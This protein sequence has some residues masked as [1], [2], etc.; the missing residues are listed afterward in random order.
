METG[1]YIQE[2]NQIYCK[3]Y[4]LPQPALPRP[5]YHKTPHRILT[6]TT[7]TPTT[8]VAS[9]ITAHKTQHY[10]N[11]YKQYKATKI[12]YFLFSATDRGSAG[13]YQTEIKQIGRCAS[14]FYGWMDTSTLHLKKD[15]TKESKNNERTT[16]KKQKWRLQCTTLNKGGNILNV[17]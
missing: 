6:T 1:K 2:I 3:I 5:T 15:N 13:S 9:T 8:K 12:D 17:S 14:N 7:N 11:N 10:N 4:K 16:Q